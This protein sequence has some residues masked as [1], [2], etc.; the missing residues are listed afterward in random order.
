MWVPGGGFW[1]V[2]KNGAEKAQNQCCQKVLLVWVC[3]VRYV[4]PHCVGWTQGVQKM[5]AEMQVAFWEGLIEELAGNA[6]SVKSIVK[7]F[8]GF[9]VSLYVYLK[10]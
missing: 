9:C 10:G 7:H 4:R 2:A 5:S 8:R 6:K 3:G 1:K